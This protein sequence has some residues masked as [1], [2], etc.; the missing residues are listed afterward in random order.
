MSLVIPGLL[1]AISLKISSQGG[2]RLVDWGLIMNGL[3]L[4]I[5]ILFL[6]LGVVRAFM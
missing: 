3:S 4:A 1:V 5:P 6:L 2:G